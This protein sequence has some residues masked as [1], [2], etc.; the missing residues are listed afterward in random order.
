MA[1]RYKFKYKQAGLVP[2]RQ[3]C[4]IKLD[5]LKELYTRSF[6]KRLYK[7]ILMTLSWLTKSNAVLKFPDMT[8]VKYRAIY[9]S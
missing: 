4:E 1:C 3:K 9:T 7:Y 5:L 2:S 8:Q 6:K